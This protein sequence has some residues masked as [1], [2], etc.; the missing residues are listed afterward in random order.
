MYEF[1]CLI[2][3]TEKQLT[4]T[5]P[6][7]RLHHHLTTPIIPTPPTPNTKRLP[8]G[9]LLF[10]ILS[11]NLWNL[12]PNGSIEN[13]AVVVLYALVYSEEILVPVHSTVVVVN[14]QMYSSAQRGDG[15]RKGGE[16]VYVCVCGGGKI[17]LTRHLAL[18]TK[19]PTCQLKLL[20]L[21]HILN[22]NHYYRKIYITQLSITPAKLPILFHIHNIIPKKNNHI[23]YINHISHTQ[24]F[25]NP[26]NKTSHTPRLLRY[27]NSRDAKPPT[28]PLSLPSST[29]AQ[30]APNPHDVE[31][32]YQLVKRKYQISTPT[33]I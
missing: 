7:S 32:S 11:Q 8:L 13:S 25:S 22:T 18:S 30:L 14:V 19:R 10:N 24:T 5:S 16:R 12:E 31:T 23:R 15:G 1:L 3:M 27:D 26:Q 4:K 33:L 9:N 6:I 28:N 2:L 21:S 29:P 20:P 17:L